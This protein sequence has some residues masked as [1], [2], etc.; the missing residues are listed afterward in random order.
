[1][2]LAE[3][4]AEALPNAELETIDDAWVFASLDAPGPVA[5]AIGRFVDRRLGRRAST[6]AEALATVA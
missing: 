5:T 6:T 3:G 4:L 1:M 2:R